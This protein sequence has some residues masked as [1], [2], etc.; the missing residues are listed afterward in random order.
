[1]LPSLMTRMLGESACHVVAVVDVD[2]I[3]Q[4]SSV[5]RATWQIDVKEWQIGY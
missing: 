4:K 1:M 3:D 5:S 2:D